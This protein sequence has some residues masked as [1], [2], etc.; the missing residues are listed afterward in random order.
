MRNAQY[1]ST[2][3]ETSLCYFCETPT[4]LKCCTMCEW[5]LHP[6][7]LVLPSLANICLAGS[8]Y[9]Y[10]PVIQ[11]IVKGSKFQSNRALANLVRDRLQPTVLPPVFFET[12]G[13]VCVPS[14]WC[15]QLWR[16]RPHIPFMFHHILTS[17]VVLN[18]S[19]KRCKYT[20]V[21]AGLTRQQRF[22]RS[23]VP[24]FE[25]RGTSSIRSVT[26][27]DDVCTTGATLTEVAKCLK[28]SGVHTVMAV[29]VAY[30]PLE[31]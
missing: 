8:F 19:L 14:H 20:R 4:N 18:K 13:F 10:T 15:R 21:S 5:Q 6:R 23:S 12:D 1:F 17:G 29:T 27:L 11:A 28:R 16:G 22:N 3:L 31:I 25:W 24:R 7:F 2:F 30:Q 26:L 9:M